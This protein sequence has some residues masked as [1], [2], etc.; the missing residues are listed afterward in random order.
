MTAITLTSAHDRTSIEV[1]PGDEI[2]LHLPENATTGFRWHVDQM[3]GPLEQVSDGYVEAEPEAP[4][5]DVQFGRGG[6]REFRFRAICPGSARLELKNWQP[7]EGEASVTE[8]FAVQITIA[9]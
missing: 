2:V 9:D 4:H 1:R 8:R 5:G 3:Q 7:W 6:I